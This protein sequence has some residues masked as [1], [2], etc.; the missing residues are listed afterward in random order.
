LL[1]AEIANNRRKNPISP[2]GMRRQP[3]LNPDDFAGM[4]ITPYNRPKEIEL[5]DEKSSGA[6]PGVTELF[7]QN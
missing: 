2:S 4:I 6:C 3:F 5:K 1:R 7:Y